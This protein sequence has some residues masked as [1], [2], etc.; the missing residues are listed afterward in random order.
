MLTDLQSLVFSALLACLMVITSSQLRTRMWTAAGLKYAFGDRHQ[1]VDVTLVAGRA[2]RAA[3][4]M[5]DNLVLFAILVLAAR[6]SGHAG[7]RTALG[8]NLFF[9]GRVAYWPL[10]LAGIP[11]FRSLAWAVTVAGLFM[12]GL[13]ALG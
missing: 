1:S 2:D 9:W 3:R 5:L 6:L 11:Y 10:Y 13:E 4:N 8:A 12:I 7:S